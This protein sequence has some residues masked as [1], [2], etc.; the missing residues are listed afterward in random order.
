MKKINKVAAGTILTIIIS[1]TFLNQL[2]MQTLK[3]EI[4]INASAEKVWNTLMNHKDYPNWNPFIIQISGSAVVGENMSVLMK[5]GNKKPMAFT[6]VVLANKKN[7]EFRWKGKVFVNGIFDGE[8][9]FILEN[10]GVNKTRFIHG[11]NFSGILSGVL[12][13]MIGKD[14]KKGFAAM[15]LAL[16]Q[17]VEK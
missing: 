1:L 15:N 14:T 5:N 9:Y 6:P 17:Q 2:T 7:E 12:L 4:K 16:K 11:E 10:L 3:T 13:K 8:H